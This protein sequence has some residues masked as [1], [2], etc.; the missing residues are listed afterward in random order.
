MFVALDDPG[1]EAVAEEVAAAL[2]AA[3]EALR[4]DAV[5][6]LHALG[7]AAELRLDDDVVVVRHQAEDV[8][9]PLVTRDH[10]GEEAQ[11]EAAFVVVQE[12]R[13]TGYSTH[14]H[15]V[16]AGIRELAP[17]APRHAA[18]LAA[19]AIA[20]ASRRASSGQTATLSSHPTRPF[21][22]SVRD[23]PCRGRR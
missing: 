16:D 23:S 6:T 19:F 1:G 22:P 10:V 2:V 8:A 18:T 5:Q 11:E 15:V 14:R 13:G 4:V 12:D 9:A 17:R 21:P 7:E 20:H 3:V